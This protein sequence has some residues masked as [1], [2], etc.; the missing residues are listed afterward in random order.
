MKYV[1]GKSVKQI[2][3][4]ADKSPK[5]TE[6][7]LQRAKGAFIKQYKLSKEREES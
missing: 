6:S 7:M 1:D 5:A 2:A 4:I 3:E